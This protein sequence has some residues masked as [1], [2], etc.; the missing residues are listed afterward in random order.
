MLSCLSFDGSGYGKSDYWHQVVYK[1]AKDF[2]EN[3]PCWQHRPFRI[4]FGE[5]EFKIK[6]Q[7]TFKDE[8]CMKSFAQTESRV[9]RLFKEFYKV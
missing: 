8:S 3:C 1:T 9:E 6:I 4:N 7:C 2:N 5:S